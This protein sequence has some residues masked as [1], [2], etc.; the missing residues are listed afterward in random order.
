MRTQIPVTVERLTLRHTS[1]ANTPYATDGRA[2][3]PCYALELTLA[4]GPLRHVVRVS[5]KDRGEGGL[6]L[7]SQIDRGKHYERWGDYHPSTK[8]SRAIRNELPRL[9]IIFA[10][11]IVAATL[12]RMADD[13]AK[14]RGG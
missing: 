10:L 5:V 4:D 8:K 11:H 3:L 6:S 12:H 14:Y 7:A 1:W 13:A 2:I 9:R